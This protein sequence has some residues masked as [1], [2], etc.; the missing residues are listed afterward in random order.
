MNQNNKKLFKNTTLFFIGSIGSKLIQ[1]LMVP[2]Y[3]YTLS[4]GDYGTVD[5]IMTTL[6]FLAP[7]FSVQITDGLLRFGLDRNCNR[8]SVINVSLIVCFF[9]S[10]SS[11]TL[12]PFILHFISLG[13]YIAFFLMIL[14]TKIFRDTLAITLKIDDDNKK[15]ALDSIIY[16]FALC[17]FSIVFLV[18]LKMGI[19]GYLLSYVI[20]N[21][22]SICYIC[23]F[24]KRQL[25]VSLK[26]CD[27]LLLKQIVIYSLPLVINSI[28]YWITTASD[29]YMINW[30]LDNEAVGQYSIAAKIPT[31]ISTLIGVFSS[32]WLITSIDAFEEK[33]N[34]N[35]YFEVYQKFCMTFFVFASMFI[36]V[37]KPFM[38][39]YVS[40]D[41]YHA[42]DLK[43][44]KSA[45][46]KN[47]I[48][49]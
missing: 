36:L 2:L 38:K 4:V 49:L 7:I 6:N 1:F 44:F 11:L 34:Y 5:I 10:I 14:I 22:I 33:E 29:K 31:I 21:I 35:Y 37:T 39:Y 19:R 12:C 17:A 25:R 28:A 9:G 15:F 41:F 16:T 23:V 3:T 13:E 18:W 20:A 26:E 46:Y 32:A 8:S 42:P 43:N 48:F 30:I 47:I 45:G 24:S 40:S 27:A